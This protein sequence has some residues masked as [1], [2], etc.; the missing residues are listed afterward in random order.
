MK[1]YIW[2][3]IAIFLLV[4]FNYSE[5]FVE[6]FFNSNAWVGNAL[7][8]GVLVGPIAYLSIRKVIRERRLSNS[9]DSHAR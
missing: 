2:I 5:P 7:I 8:I 6:R 1:K 9:T 3:T 4:A